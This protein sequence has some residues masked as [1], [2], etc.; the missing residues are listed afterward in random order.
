MGVI[1]MDERFSA[2]ADAQ[3]R[4]DGWTECEPAPLAP[5]TTWCWKVW[6][7]TARAYFNSSPAM[8]SCRTCVVPAPISI[9][10]PA[11]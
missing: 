1:L 5:S 4:E 3:N 11:R 2:T 8:I 9:S 6:R 7:A 10:F